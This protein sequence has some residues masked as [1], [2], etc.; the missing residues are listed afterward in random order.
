M[1]TFRSDKGQNQTV[2]TVEST[3]IPGGRV[4]TVTTKIYSTAPGNSGNYESSEETKEYATSGNDMS[5]FKGSSDNLEQ[6]MLKQSVM[7][8]ITE[9]KT[10]TKTTSSRQEHNTKSFRFEDK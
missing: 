7:Q 3:A 2:R 8:K 9:K 4:E 5:T 6:K 10:I 1:S